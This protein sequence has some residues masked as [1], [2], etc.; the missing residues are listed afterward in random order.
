MRV[1]TLGWGI[2]EL[3]HDDAIRSLFFRC[4]TVLDSSGRKESGCCHNA[5]RWTDNQDHPLVPPERLESSFSF[6]EERA[7]TPSYADCA[8]KK[9]AD[10]CEPIF[11]ASFF[12][13]SPMLES[14]AYAATYDYGVTTSAKSISLSILRKYLHTKWAKVNYIGPN[15]IDTTLRNY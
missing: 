14:H 8:V 13:V 2:H 7:S 11:S 15:Y 12:A 6:I 10:A 9:V 4:S 1:E 5:T 3:E